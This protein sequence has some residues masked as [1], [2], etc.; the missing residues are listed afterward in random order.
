MV[1][2]EN[3]MELTLVSTA[4][5][6]RW[7][8]YHYQFTLSLEWNALLAEVSYSNKWTLD[9]QWK[10]AQLWSDQSRFRS[11]LSWATISANLTLM[12]HRLHCH[13]FS[14]RIAIN[15]AH[16]TLDTSQ[17][18]NNPDERMNNHLPFRQIF[19]VGL[20]FEGGM[21]W[22]LVWIS[23]TRCFC[24]SLRITKQK[25]DPNSPHDAINTILLLRNL[26]HST[27][28]VMSFSKQLICFWVKPFM[29][30]VNFVLNTY[31]MSGH[32]TINE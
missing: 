3:E 13:L 16:R 20:I 5:W 19:I 12:W 25:C 24:F 9:S 26:T 14:K 6:N 1:S 21:E 29:S 8:I 18:T 27:H 11:R 10:M 4:N 32:W 7:F 17:R 2:R 28:M 15:D 30:S 31:A 23:A 22:F